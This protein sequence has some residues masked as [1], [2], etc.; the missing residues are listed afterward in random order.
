MLSH[1]VEGEPPEQVLMQMT[2]GMWAAQAVAT[3]ARLGIA[4]ALAQSQPQDAATLARAVRADAGALSRLLRALASIGV[5]AEPVPRQYALN[6][7]GTLLRSDVSGSMRDWLIAETDTPHWQAW[8]KLHEGVRTGKTIVPQLFGTHIYEYYAAH[9]DDLACFSAAMGNVSKLVAQGTVQHYD[10]SRA[11]HI[12]DVGG[13]QGDL[14]LAI[15]D[16]NPHARGTVFDQPQVIEA[17]RQAIHAKGHQQRCEAVGG[18]FFQAVPPGGDLYVLKFI[19]VDWRDAEASQILHN[20]RTAMV[21]DGKL[22]VIEMTIPDDNHPTPAQL[23]DLNMLVMTGGQERTV[24]EYESLF[25][26]QNFRLTSVIPTGSP[27]HLL[28]AAAV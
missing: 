15:L 26:K 20:C 5:F 7:V 25:A 12:I 4:D 14:L 23:F 13:A 6:A 1:A 24:S 16:A 18:N 9:P 3:A 2:L 21:P 10:F 17:A 19:L 27:F 11:R 22:L 28:E 8:G